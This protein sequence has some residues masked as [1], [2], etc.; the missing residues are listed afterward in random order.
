M[1]TYRK[2]VFVAILSILFSSHLFIAGTAQ[3]AVGKWEVFELT[4]TSTNSYGNPYTAVSLSATFTSPTS[5]TIQI[6][7]FWDGGQT[8]KVRMAPNEI[9]TWTYVTTS[10]D[11]QLNNQNGQFECVASGKRGFIQVDPS[12]PYKFRYNDGTPFF[13][14]GDTCWHL[15]HNDI[16]Y[17][18]DF[19]NYIDRRAAQHF[20]NIHAGLY[21]GD[22][23]ENEGGKPFPAA[24]GDMDTLNPD[25][26]RYV[27]R[28]VEYITSKG[29]VMGLFLTWAQQFVYFTRPQFERY[30][31]Y[32]I[33][34]YAA[35]N[36]YW[37]VSG[38]YNEASTP[39]E[40]AYHGNV[41]DQVDPYGHP[42]S[43]HTTT[44]NNEFGNDSWLTYI[45][46]QKFEQDSSIML[47]DLLAQLNRPDVV[48]VN[49]VTTSIADGNHLYNEI[50]IDRIFDKLFSRLDDESVIPPC[51]LAR[52]CPIIASHRPDLVQRIVNELLAIDVTHHKTGRKDLIKAD[53]IL[54]L[55]QLYGRVEDQ[56]G[57]L[58]FVEAQ[59]NCSSPKTRK[60]AKAFLEKH[61]APGGTNTPI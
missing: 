8:W 11:N 53:I 30:E 21:C 60:A 15:F 1:N 12:D 14:M 36:V 20:T 35:Y 22:V 57:V 9:G 49:N 43:I 37:V 2:V 52:N 16:V 40:Y 46:H 29:M 4:L 27:D 61:R 13:W 38:E 23:Y 31:K 5:N 47:S 45:M 24:P 44:T 58:R 42:I 48:I 56:P 26:F 18:G 7:G 6:P 54:A 39:S 32:V 41:I 17:D 50:Q 51:Y 10:N 34:R 59:L 19:K 3:A 25:Y 28:K 55:D 33:A